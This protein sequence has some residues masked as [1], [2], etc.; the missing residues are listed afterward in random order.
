[1]RIKWLSSLPAMDNILKMLA[2]IAKWVARVKGVDAKKK[3][4]PAPRFVAA[5]I[6]T[7]NNVK[8]LKIPIFIMILAWTIQM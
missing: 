7:I 2:A 3:I 1:M 8:I 5:L 4:W 6:V